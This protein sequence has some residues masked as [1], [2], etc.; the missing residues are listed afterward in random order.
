MK[1]L[2]NNNLFPVFL[3]G[4]TLVI[5]FILFGNNL[6]KK[7]QPPYTSRQPESFDLS[8]TIA[9]VTDWSTY[10]SKNQYPFTI[11]YPSNWHFKDNFGNTKRLIYFQ[12]HENPRIAWEQIRLQCPFREN[13][14]ILFDPRE[15]E[16]NEGGYYTSYFEN[17]EGERYDGIKYV[18]SSPDKSFNE[19]C[20]AFL[21]KKYNISCQI[22]TSLEAK[23][24]F[25]KDYV[26]SL[27]LYQKAVSSFT[28]KE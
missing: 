27:D 6:F 13:E 18:W 7:M 24:A 23:D 9:P 5:I 1:K 10:I 11:N 15:W 8:P 26:E 14:N 12:Y 21:F 20:T 17:Y 16:N 4:M 19:L 28:L 3:S 22:C 25:T 2:V